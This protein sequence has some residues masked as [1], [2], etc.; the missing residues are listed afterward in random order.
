MK[1]INTKYTDISQVTELLG[2]N[3]LDKN[4]NLPWNSYFSSSK[5]MKDINYE[6]FINS[7]QTSYPFS[8]QEMGILSEI[9]PISI[10]IY[11]QYGIITKYMNENSNK[12]INI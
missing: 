1:K 11:N 9:F 7:L 5:Y 12:Y 8:H 6:E 10:V 2:Y 4:A 3:P